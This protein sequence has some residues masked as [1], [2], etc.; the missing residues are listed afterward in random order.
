[1]L[2]VRLYEHQ[3]VIQVEKENAV[4]HVPEHVVYQL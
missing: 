3:T 2:L 4:E 1:M